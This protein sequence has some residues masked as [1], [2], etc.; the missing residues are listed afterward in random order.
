MT[1]NALS[2][3]AKSSE[4]SRREQG[5]W[6]NDVAGTFPKYGDHMR[7]LKTNHSKETTYERALLTS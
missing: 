3:R 4:Y 6:T 1:F 2:D 5:R 7:Q